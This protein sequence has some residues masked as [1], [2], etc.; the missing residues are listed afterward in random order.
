MSRRVREDILARVFR[1]NDFHSPVLDNLQAL[2]KELLNAADTPLSPLPNDEG[3]DIKL[4][5]ETLLDDAIK[6]RETW[7]SAPWVLAEFYL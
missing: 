4:W 1:E 2:E 6:K 3:P 5:N 7:L